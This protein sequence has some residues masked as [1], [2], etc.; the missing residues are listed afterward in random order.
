MRTSLMLT[1]TAALSCLLSAPAAAQWIDFPTPGVPRLPNGKPNLAAPAPRS[2][3]S[4]SAPAAVPPPVTT[5]SALA[6]IRPSPASG[7]YIARLASN[8]SRTQ[9]VLR[10]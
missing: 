1:A 5:P 6:A 4:R 2:R 10:G 8:T 3:P 7:A 9:P